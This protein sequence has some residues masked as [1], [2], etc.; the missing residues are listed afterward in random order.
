MLTSANSADA[1]VIAGRLANPAA[2]ADIAARLDRLPPSRYLWNLVL[3]LS[4]GAFFEIYD[5]L[6]TG[7]VSPGLFRSGAFTEG[8][9]ALFGLS[10]QAAFASA[11]FAGLWIGTLWLGSVADRFG[12]RAIFTSALLVY[13]IATFVM[14]MQSTAIG[15]FAWRFIAGVGIGCEMVTI[16]TY[17]CELV[18]KGLRGR[19]FAVSQGI[20]FC[21]VP[22][23]ALLSWLLL[24]YSPLG[25]EGWRW[26][27]LF[28]ALGAILVWWIR[29]HLPESPRWLAD[30]GRIDAALRI[31]V[32]MEDRVARELGRELPLPAPPAQ[33]FERARTAG[34]R[35]L[36]R[37]PYRRRTLMLIVFHLFQ[38]IGFY[39]FGNWVPKLI[40]SQGITI[41]SSLKYA[42]I[43]AMVYPLGP[44]LFTLIADRFE[45]KWQIVASATGTALFG[46]LFARQTSPALLILF[47]ILITLSNNLLSYSYHA[48]QTELFPTHIRA[49]AVG[50]VYSFSRLSTIFTSFMI[51]FVLQR[52]G[53]NG[54]CVFIASSM[55]VVVLAIGF[56]GPRTRDRGLEVIAGA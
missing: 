39:G 18:P 11:T 40:S 44:F 51:A 5:L 38:A 27:A 15:I 24:P 33:S 56:F 9:G 42:F 14:A 26:V 22:I 35:E 28:P 13:A 12:R 6:M 52:S 50:F 55:A 2:G 3:L 29:R 20:M 1:A 36:F 4:L 16:D 30:Q 25:I 17:I 21:A 45:R 10:D 37:P 34:L 54:V 46:L 43:I 47:G 41:T 8:H 48:Y 49:R 53:T 32:A 31:T 23:V 19:A 7:Y